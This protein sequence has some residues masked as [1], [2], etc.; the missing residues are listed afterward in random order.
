MLKELTTAEK[1]SASSTLRAEIEDCII[2]AVA[3]VL[4]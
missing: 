3:R 2:N 4:K 1:N